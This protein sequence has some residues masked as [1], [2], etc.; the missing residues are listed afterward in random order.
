MGLFIALG[1]LI[2]LLCFVLIYSL[3]I[4]R[5]RKEEKGLNRHLGMNIAATK[6]AH[7]FELKSGRGGM[8][9]AV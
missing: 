5:A 2:P 8:F 7:G 3:Q 6:R 9:V 1:K 4:L